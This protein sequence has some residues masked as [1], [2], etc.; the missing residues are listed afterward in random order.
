MLVPPSCLPLCN[1]TDC[2]PW[3]SFVYGILQARILERVAIPFSR[4]TTWPRDWTCVSCIA[5]RFFTVWVTVVFPGGSPGEGNGN[6]HQYS[7]LKNSMDRGARWTYRPWY[8]R[9]R[10]VLVRARAHTYTHTHTH[11]HSKTMTTVLE[12]L[13]QSASALSVPWAGKG[14]FQSTP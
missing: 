5:G 13:F 2:S 3:G 9:V 7:C 1:P 4:G 10:H 11:T 14:S 6:T 8:C 12:K